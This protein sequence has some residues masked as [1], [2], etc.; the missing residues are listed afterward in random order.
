MRIRF[1]LALV[2]ATLAHA[3]RGQPLGSEFR[4]NSYTSF[5]QYRPKVG[6][7]PDG[8][9]LVVWT[10]AFQDGSSSGIFAQSYDGAGNALGAEFRVNGTTTNSQDRATVASASNGVFAVVWS[11]SNQ[12]GDGL[13]VFAQR[14]GSAGAPLGSQFRVNSYTTGNQFFPSLTSLGGSVFVVAWL[15]SRSADR[16]IFGQR[17]DASGA[18][19]GSEFQV[20]V[21]T[22]NP[23]STS[24]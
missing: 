4:V 24:V 11:S 5:N 6:C 15:D 18:L 13:G 3:L 16:K 21:G 9:F 7:A 14:Y 22:S 19:L 12:D 20:T 10:S 23:Y 8:S 1:S 2:L 17:F